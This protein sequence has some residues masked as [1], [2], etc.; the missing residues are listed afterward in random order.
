M[1][2]QII[3]VE[4]AIG[5]AMHFDFGSK[6][7]SLS[8]IGFFKIANTGTQTHTVDKGSLLSFLP[9]CKTTKHFLPS[10]AFL[11]GD[12]AGVVVVQRLAC[13]KRQIGRAS[14]RDSV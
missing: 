11:G 9:A 5:Y 13:Q 7:A 1:A 6:S 3:F 12:S 14:C 2:L 10:F 8:W 4:I